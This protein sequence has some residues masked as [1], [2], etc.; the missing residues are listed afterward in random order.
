MGT[1]MNP[2][3]AT[4]VRAVVV[5]A[6][7]L[8]AGLAGAESFRIGGTGAALGTMRVLGE[9]FRKTRPGLE[10]EV[11]P[12]LGS[13][14]GIRAVLGGAIEIG[15]SARP[16]KPE[17]LAAGAVQTPVGTTPFVFAVAA[18][19]KV[20]ALSSADLVDIYAGTKTRWPDGSPVRLML[21]SPS[22]AEIALIYS[23]SPQM[24]EAHVLAEKRPGLLTTATDQENAEALESIPGAI[25]VISFAQLVSEKRSLQALQIDGVA[26]S[27][28][29][30][31]EG[32]YRLS[33]PLYFV[34]GARPSPRAREFIAFTRS[35]A[36]AA[37]LSRNGYLVPAPG[38]AR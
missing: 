36:G 34:T 13:P 38:E 14:G 16:L 6:L 28:A 4:R 15:V 7:L 29:A 27:P 2:R 31:R 19:S 10:V 17:E 3:F 23:I 33:V 1:A 22:G 37:L 8:F 9:E 18:A 24:K 21:R 20:T 35:A 5:S 26:P 11:L 32:S 12:S 25:G 30:L